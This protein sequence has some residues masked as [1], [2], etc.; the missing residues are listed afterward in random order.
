MNENVLWPGRLLPDFLGNRRRIIAPERRESQRSADGPGPLDAG[1]SP[2]FSEVAS[3]STLTP[4]SFRTK[5]IAGLM[6]LVV[7]V[8]MGLWCV[9]YRSDWRSFVKIQPILDSSSPRSQNGYT[10][11]RVTVV[12]TSSNGEAF[13]LLVRP[14]FFPPCRP[15]GTDSDDAMQFEPSERQQRFPVQASVRMSTGDITPVLCRLVGTTTKPE[16]LKIPIA[17]GYS[18]KCRF[19]DVTLVPPEG[20]FIHWRLNHLPFMH[21]AI[22][23]QPIVVNRSSNEGI[24]ASAYAWRSGHAI[25]LHTIPVIPPNSHQWEIVKNRSSSQYEKLDARPNGP[26]NALPI[27]LYQGELIPKDMST[28]GSLTTWFPAPYRSASR[29]VRLDCTLRQFET[30]DERVTF[31]NIAVVKDL[32]N[33]GHRPGYGD[34]NTYY[35]SVAKP[36]TLQTPSGLAVTLPT[37]GKNNSYEAD[38]INFTLTVKLDI[39]PSELPASPLIKQFGKSITVSVK[40][41]PPD[42]LSGWSMNPGKTQH[43]VLWSP[44]NPK[45]PGKLNVK[46]L[47]RTPL[48]MSPPPRR[49]FTVILHERVELQ[50]IP[51]TF[52]VP[53]SD[54]PPPDFH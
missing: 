22:P 2:P 6:A 37:Q 29:F 9:S 44:Q 39:S 16:Y 51:M 10:L 5:L 34:M 24:S 1:E 35:I 47:W 33:S 17:G 45:W 28:S 32:E 31:T 19:A 23:D 49:D 48:F 30:V 43:Y 15:V 54:T 38:K 8:G 18:N 21:Q 53:V 11:A 25:F 20:A 50:T 13:Y 7:L 52:T 42:E 40:L 4:R 41:A 3:M 12:E 27:I 14:P 36:I 46:E 26:S